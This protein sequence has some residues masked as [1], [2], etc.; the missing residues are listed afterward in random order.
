MTV[1]KESGVT[2]EIG[3]IVALA[4]LFAEDAVLLG[5]K[6]AAPLDGARGCKLNENSAFAPIAPIAM[7]LSPEDVWRKCKSRAAS[8][9]I[10]RH[11]M[12]RPH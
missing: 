6:F 5:K 8:G 1:S 9:A 12:Q 7:S 4:A 3:K 11:L 2:A 10:H